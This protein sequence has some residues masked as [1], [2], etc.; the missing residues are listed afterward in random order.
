MIGIVILRAWAGTGSSQEYSAV[1]D[2]PGSQPFGSRQ[3]RGVLEGTRVE[4]EEVA[5]LNC[6][7]GMEAITPPV[8]ERVAM[9]EVPAVEVVG[10]ELEEPGVRGA[11]A[12][13]FFEPSKP[14]SRPM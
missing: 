6:E 14:S 13:V 9:T 3:I 2:L 11:G 8:L 12:E 1:R 7:L 5:A 10:A 4:D